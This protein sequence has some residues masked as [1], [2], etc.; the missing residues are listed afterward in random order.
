MHNGSFISLEE[1]IE[2]YNMGGGAGMKLDVPNQ[3]L[4]SDR[5]NLSRQ[6]KKDIISFINALTDTSGMSRF[7][8]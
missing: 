6:D 1:V 3:T 7:R 5:L 8:L 4:S 2:F